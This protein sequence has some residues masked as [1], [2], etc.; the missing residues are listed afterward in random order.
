VPTLDAIIAEVIDRTTKAPEDPA[1]KELYQDGRDF[2]AWWRIRNPIR[3]KFRSL[4]QIPGHNWSSGLGASAVFGRSQVSFTYWD[5]DG[6]SFEDICGS[7]AVANPTAASVGKPMRV[8][9]SNVMS[10]ATA[11]ASNTWSRPIFPLCGVDFSG[12]EEDSRLGNRKIWIATWSSQVNVTLRCGLNEEAADKVCRRDLPA[13]IKAEGGWWSLDFPFGIAKESAQAMGLSSWPDWLRWCGSKSDATA[14]R[15]QARELINRAG[16]SWAQRRQVDEANQTTWFPLFEQLYRQTIYGAREVLLP[17]YDEGL[18]I[19]PWRWTAL[20]N[21]TV[22]VEG[23][24]GATVRDH[25]LK[26]RVSYKGSTEAHRVARQAIINAL[27]SPPYQLP[28][29]DDVAYQAVA[30]RDGDGLDALVLLLASWISQRLPQET[31]ERQASKLNSQGAT[32]EGW[33]PI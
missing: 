4:A 9:V 23:F 31:W 5:F 29:P 32:V 13:L 7:A 18:C 28:I 21:P 19:L 16:L 26:R 10:S 22:V 20:K 11:V 6:A 1:A 24:P 8:A 3:A 15:D 33:F 30:D 2:A 12:G 27:K 14:L 17:L 25:L